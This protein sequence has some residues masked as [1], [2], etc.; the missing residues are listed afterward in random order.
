MRYSSCSEAKAAVKEYAARDCFAEGTEAYRTFDPGAGNA[1]FA[2]FAPIP[3]FWLIG[4]LLL[5]IV[6]WVS[7]GFKQT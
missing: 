7:R 5:V 3:V 2:A 1:A 6:R 4:W